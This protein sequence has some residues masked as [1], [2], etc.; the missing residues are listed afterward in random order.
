MISFLADQNFNE[1][2]VN[3]L[4]RRDA[5]LRFT[6][7][8]DVGLAT[9][10]DPALLEWAASHSLVLLSHDARTISA[11]AHAC[12][13]AGKP[14]SGVFLVERSHAGRPGDRR[15]SAGRPMSYAR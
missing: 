5:S 12:T 3:G 11:F 13:T 7:A 6:L 2:I 15:D 9:A 14:M 10:D 8:R 1:H 4:T